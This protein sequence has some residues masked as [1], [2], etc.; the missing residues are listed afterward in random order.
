MRF[1]AVAIEFLPAVQRI[2]ADGFPD[3][4]RINLVDIVREVVG[5]EHIEVVELTM[6][7]EH[8]LP[9]SITPEVIS[10]LVDLKDEL[11]HSYTV[12]LPL[13]S[14]E[15]ATFNDFIRSGGVESICHSIKKSEPLEPEAYVLHTSGSLAAE[16]TRNDYSEA[17]NLLVCGYMT[18][19]SMK[20]VEEIISKTET[21]SRKLAIENIEFPF[22]FTRDI[23]D[24]HDTSICFDTG[25]ALTKQSGDESV[26]EFYSQHRDRIVEV[27][28]NDGI[29]TG[30]PG[31]YEDHLIIGKGE[32][33]VR[34]FLLELK[35]ND[36]K[37]PLIFELTTEEVAESLQGIREVVPEALGSQT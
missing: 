33:P 12:H 15:L 1:G 30:T 20:S 25:H 10:Q 35:R 5:I 7:M 26:L 6:E 16:F 13:W 32:L 31:R 28:L 9:G 4:S 8:M 3:F 36:F 22:E 23:V 24:E 11:G 27:H 14:I 34:D 19:F 29:D 37:G 17:M 18:E 21:D 2:L